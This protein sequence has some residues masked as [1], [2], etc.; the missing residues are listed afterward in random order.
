MRMSLGVTY[1]RSPCRPLAMIVEAH[2]T[3]RSRL[4]P[5]GRRAYKTMKCS[6]QLK[7]SLNINIKSSRAIEECREIH[8]VP[9]EVSPNTHAS[10]MERGEVAVPVPRT[11]AVLNIRVQ[12]SNRPWVAPVAQAF[13][14]PQQMV[15]IWG[16]VLCRPLTHNPP[17]PCTIQL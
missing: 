8:S 15:Y 14:N 17:T 3:F 10:E 2:R 1:K 9:R 7:P 12:V 5:N 6:I 13:L 11:L 4:F 16:A